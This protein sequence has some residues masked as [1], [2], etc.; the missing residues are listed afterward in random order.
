M[1]T[2]FNTK[3][4]HEG[5]ADHYGGPLITPIYQTATF[6]FDKLDKAKDAIEFSMDS[7]DPG[8]A[9]SR[10]SN[11]TH[12]ALEK[13]V[14]SLEEGGAAVA[15]A[16]GMAAITSAALAV[17]NKG[18]HVISAR[19]IYTASHSF[20]SKLP[21]WGVEVSFVDQTK[22]SEIADNIRDNTKLI[23]LES[24]S[25]P[26]LDLADIGEIVNLAKGKNIKIMVDNTFA[27]PYYQRPLSIGA[28]IVIHSTT[29]YLC[30]HLDTMGGI[31]VGNKG[32][33]K[34]S[35]EAITIMGGIMNPFNAWLIMR[36]TKTLSLRMEKHSMN[37]QRLAEWLESNP[38]IERVYYPGLASH[39]QHEL[40][41][42][43]MEGFGG[44]VSFEVAG[45]RKGVRK[46]V[47]NMKI[48]SLA[49]SLGGPETLMEHVETMSHL[50]MSAEERAAL[51][52]GEGLIRMSVGLED[53]EDIIQDISSAL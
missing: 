32:I 41:A 48:C 38:K 20:F 44:M 31:I 45:G 18:D 53:V 9:Y 1:D 21:S 8:Y 34:S 14:A 5:E 10:F 35:A 50:N 42:R 23:F 43:Q 25:N 28:D 40:A 16:S 19:G 17:I 37:A 49:V 11:P 15:T 46:L 24:P 52:I 27:T 51:G 36:G 7:E 26:L 29:K 12:T 39:P 2:G 22:T 47:E 13:K 4:V 30:G 3:A 6:K 33:V